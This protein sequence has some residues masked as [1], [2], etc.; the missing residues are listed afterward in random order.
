MDFLIIDRILPDC[1]V[2][3]HSFNECEYGSGWQLASGSQQDAQ[4]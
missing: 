3:G 1:F 4:W 2:A